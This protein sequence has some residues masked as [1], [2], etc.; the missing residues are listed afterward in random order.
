[1]SKLRLHRAGIFPA[2]LSS[3]LLVGGMML[4]STAAAQSPVPFNERDDQYPL[5]GLKRAKEAYDASR[6]EFERLS[7]LHRKGLITAQE[8][9]QIRSRYVNDEVN[10]Q[11]SLLA[12]MFEKQ[13]VSVLSAVKYLT[14][15]GERRVRV[16]LANTATTSAESFALA[17][18]N[19]SLFASLHPDEI[20]N[21]YVSLL[22][23]DQA[24]I[25]RPYEKKIPI[26]K[27]NEP[28]TVDFG[29]L[30]EL[31]NVVVSLIYGRGSSR[32]LNIF[33]QKDGTLDRIDIRSDQF[34]QEVDLGKTAKFNLRLEMFSG[35]NHAYALGVTNLPKEVTARFV[36]PTTGARLN[37]V[38]FDEG[39]RGKEVVLEV[40]LPDRPGGG[41]ILDS[42]ISFQVIARNA[43]SGSPGQA[44]KETPGEQ[45]EEGGGFAKLQLLPRGRGKIVVKAQQLF[46]AIEKSETATVP[47]T[48][49][50]DGS[51]ELANIEAQLDLPLGWR[52]KTDPV[53]IAELAIGRETE[54]RVV[55]D[56]APETE[57]GR[58][59]I[60]VRL[61]ATSAGEPVT[62]IEKT[63]TVEVKPARQFWLTA[64]ISLVVLG[65][66]GGIVLLGIRVAR[67]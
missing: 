20:P 43:E 62:E 44:K 11:Q 45:K 13:F 27:A 22:N 37:Q 23:K 14:A 29:L 8:L 47:L 3:A 53:G 12:V 33:L 35:G 6:A 32:Q 41:V 63:L 49:R 19:D 64:I 7:E 55:L 58:Y 38:R 66:V 57:A 34:S 2:M 65:L 1:M 9:E 5:L 31:D 15:T 25:S 54:L 59:D 51:H 17:G 24:I 21:V 4:C 56:P 42:M 18:L 26:L 52:G 28:V 40:S 36:E 16:T 60:R 67:K 50:N 46:V 39:N 48:L 61:S 30:Q 10:Y